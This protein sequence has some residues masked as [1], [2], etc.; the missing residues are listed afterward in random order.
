MNKS[1][2]F[3]WGLTLVALG[4]CMTNA[5]KV[6]VPVSTTAAI[7]DTYTI[8]WNGS[9]LA[10]R[11]V[12]GT[13]QR[14]ASYDYVFDVVQKRYPDTWKSVKSL[15][16][17]HPEYDGKAGDRS[18]VMYFQL[19]YQPNEAANALTSRLA[20]SL[21]EG[22]GKSDT[23]FRNQTLEF[24]VADISRFAPYDHIRITQNYNYEEGVLTETVL[25]YKKKNKDEIPFMK[26]E[27]KAYFYVRG[28][29]DKAPTTF[30]RSTH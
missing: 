20:S 15:H 5:Q 3:V 29:L 4:G 25:L 1:F 21:G 11:F 18:Q 13:W 10:Y 19:T 17:L 28:K 12:D 23:E 27:E 2:I 14:D 9:S 24:K 26:N 16:R 7:E 22:N 6:V 30:H 8:I